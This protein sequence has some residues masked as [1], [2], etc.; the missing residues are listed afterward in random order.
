MANYPE[1][2]YAFIEQLAPC[3]FV[4][5][6]SLDLVNGNL[7]IGASRDVPGFAGAMENF[8]QLMTQYELYSWDPSINDG[9]PFTRSDYFSRRQFR[10]T[11]IYAEVYQPLGIDDHCAVHVSGTDSEVAF[12]GIERHRGP[13]YSDDERD[14][15]Q[16]AQSILGSARNL[17]RAR[18]RQSASEANPAALCRAGLSPREADV[19]ALVADGKTNDEIGLIL[20]I[21]SSTVKDYL[22]QTFLKSGCP[23]RLAATMWALRI[24]QIDASRRQRVLL[25][26]VT[27]PVAGL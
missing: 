23:N 24:T 15:L 2:A 7:E 27:V 1:R 13:D 20:G 25:P 9:Q 11:D 14:L 22:K 18:D 26:N 16:M 12:F 6:G 19:L 8:G 21:Q 10:D 17:A 5:F 4:A 3:E